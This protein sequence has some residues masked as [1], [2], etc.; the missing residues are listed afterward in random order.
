MP[1]TFEPRLDILPAP[2]RRLWDE[3]RQIPTHFTLYG[4]TAIALRLGHRA[5]IDFDLFSSA[6][7]DPR[8]LLDDLPMLAG[9]T[10]TQVEPETLSV[11]VDRDGPVK[12]SFFG[13]PK[14]G[15]VRNPAP[16]PGIGLAI[17]HLLDLA[18][19]KV[20]VIQVRAEPKDYIDVDA[21]MS[22][23]VTLPEMLSAGLALYG[24]AFSRQS[25]LKA[26]TY[27]DDPDLAVLDAGLRRRLLDAVK[28]VNLDSAP[29]L[30]PVAPR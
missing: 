1:A 8:R 4:G 19:S 15:R 27:F 10:V 25:A 29:D 9:A 3:L 24:P 12:L 17:A 20:S 16:A 18:G 26:L 7:I 21:L 14:L 6:S 22:A 23:G 5:S 28:C 2:Q 11:I 30:E 13:V